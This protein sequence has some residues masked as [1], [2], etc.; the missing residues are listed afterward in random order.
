[1]LNLPLMWKWPWAAGPKAGFKWAYFPLRALQR[2]A[3]SGPIECQLGEHFLK[4]AEG[5]AVESVRTM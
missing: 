3:D 4:I 2:N 1:M 5:R